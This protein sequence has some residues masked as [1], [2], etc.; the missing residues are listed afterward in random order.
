MTV[1]K[2]LGVFCVF[3]L[4]SGCNNDSET[5][6]MNNLNG[7]WPQKA[8]QKFDF[9]VTD[10]QNP[11]NIIFVVRNNNEYPYSNIRFIVNFM[12]TKTNKKSTDTL[13]Y[14]LAKPNGE[15][16]GKGFGDTKETLFQYK[17]NYKFPQNGQYNIGIIHAMR[18]DSLKGIEDI[19]VKIEAVKP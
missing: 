1:H 17:L 16:I 19:G 12:E 7:L 9:E 18:T 11:K 2:I 13:N 10:A 3:L 5:V 15:W 8:E 4:F 6:K 14:V